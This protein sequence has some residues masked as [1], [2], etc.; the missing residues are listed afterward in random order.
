MGLLVKLVVPTTN[1]QLT[2]Y[3]I[4]RHLSEKALFKFN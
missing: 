4:L 1:E 3:Q 2:H